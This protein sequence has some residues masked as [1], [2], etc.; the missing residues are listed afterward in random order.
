MACTGLRP[1][2]LSELRRGILTSFSIKR[3]TRLIAAQGY[4]FDI[5]VKPR[6]P[7]IVQGRQ[8]SVTVVR[9]DRFNRP[10]GDS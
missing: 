4:D 3:L 7:A 9:Y 5:S 10:L 2:R 8:P 6:D 1:S